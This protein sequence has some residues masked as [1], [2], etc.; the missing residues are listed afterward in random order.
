MKTAKAI[1]HI[2][3]RDGVKNQQVIGIY[4][5]DEISKAINE[6]KKRMA[7]AGCKLL[8]EKKDCCDYNLRFENEKEVG[9][10]MN[11]IFYTESF[12]INELI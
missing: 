11:I 3:Y 6:I 5:S 1:T 12:I 2:F 9:S 10:D 8:E 7:D 4:S